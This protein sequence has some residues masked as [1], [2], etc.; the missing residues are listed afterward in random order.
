M[1]YDTGLIAWLRSLHDRR[2]RNQIDSS[3][4]IDQRF[5]AMAVTERLVKLHEMPN[6]TEATDLPYAL[7]VELTS[8]GAQ[9]LA[10][11]P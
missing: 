5:S 7:L 3:D 4:A 2:P 1:V 9:A 6:Y 11:N 8:L 10:D